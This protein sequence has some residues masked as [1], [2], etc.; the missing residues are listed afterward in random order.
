MCNPRKITARAT[1]QISE[2]WRAAIQRTAR[3]SGTATGR[4]ELTQPLGSM[5]SGPAR[6]AF[7]QAVTADPRWQ[8]RDG[9][10]HLEVPGGEV[11]YR[12][13][14]GE[15]Q[16]GVELSAYVEA[17]G[18]AE[19]IVE[20]TV[21]A[22]VQAT[23]QAQ[24]YTDG[25]GGRTRE[26][27]EQEARELAEQEARRKSEREAESLRRKAR[28]RADRA[29]LADGAEVQREAEADAASR[30]DAERHRRS[31]ELTR[32]AEMQLDRVHQLSL[33]GMW[34]TVALGYQNAL[35]AYARANGARDI[36]VTRQGSSMQVQFQMEA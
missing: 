5:L 22:T 10:Y 17:E 24:Y 29:D 9:G 32:E 6:R 27:A 19:R 31:E 11:C 14:T 28:Q 2:A 7:E 13:D 16:I 36:A 35:L 34:E 25:Y 33:H 12:P 30:L 18:S 21:E 26:R 20:G 8:L 3:L 4:A 23:A 1:R 15:L